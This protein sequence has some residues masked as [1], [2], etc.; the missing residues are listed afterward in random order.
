MLAHRFKLSLYLVSG[1]LVISLP[2]SQTKILFVSKKNKNP[3]SIK[4]R[5]TVDRSITGLWKLK[6][7]KITGLVN[8]N[9]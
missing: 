8:L 9:L 1:H 5:M 7:L 3:L 2:K 6:S 4:K